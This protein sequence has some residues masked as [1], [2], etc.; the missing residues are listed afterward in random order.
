MIYRV[1]LL[2]SRIILSNSQLQ[3]T[4]VQLHLEIFS[5]APNCPFVEIIWERDFLNLFP[6]SFMLE[7]KIRFL[8]FFSFELIFEVG[9]L[10]FDY[11]EKKCLA[12]VFPVS[13]PANFTMTLCSIFNKILF[14]QND[15]ENYI[16]LSKYIVTAKD[17]NRS[18]G[19][20]SQASRWS[21]RRPL[22][23]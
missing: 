6:K 23:I 13:A 10:F 16:W 14:S 4:I 3:W 9:R 20:K 11:I 12:R 7:F 21:L 5:I 15:Y 2:C 1:S 19:F 17:T 18:T 8:I 22:A